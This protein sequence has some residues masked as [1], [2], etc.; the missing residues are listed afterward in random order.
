MAEEIANKFLEELCMQSH[1]GTDVEFIIDYLI[2]RKFSLDAFEY[3][4]DYFDIEPSSVRHHTDALRNADMND[5]AEW[6]IKAN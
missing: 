2:E 6:L 1:H 4:L 3:A 5:V